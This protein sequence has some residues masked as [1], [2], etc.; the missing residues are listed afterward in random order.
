MADRV[1]LE[2]AAD[3][4]LAA[5]A[6]GDIP[7]EIFRAALATFLAGKRL[8]MR[9]LSQELGIARAT[10]Y[11]KVGGRDRLLGEMLWHLCAQALLPAFQ[12]AGDLTGP[13]RVKSIAA[14]FMRNLH[15]QPAFR[16]LLE[17][18]PEAAL[19]ILTSRKGPVQGRVIRA[20]QALLEEEQDRGTLKL[21][22]D[23]PTLAYVIVRIGESFLYAD[24]IADNE[25]DLDRAVEVI[26]RLLDAS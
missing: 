4:L 11:R 12:A 22:L 21:M 15:A 10:L 25:V 13:E 26:G 6:P 19:R 24:V 7:P 1:T 3:R 17:T 8:D 20:T 2:E 23:A 18:E 14:R 9:A 16:H 5:P